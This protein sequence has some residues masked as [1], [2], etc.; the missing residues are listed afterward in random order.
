MW[1]N[2][3]DI[4]DINFT[5]QQCV[6]S[7][8]GLL[9]CR[10][11]RAHAHD[12][13]AQYWVSTAMFERYLAQ[14]KH[15]WLAVKQALRSEDEST[16]YDGLKCLFANDQEDDYE[17]AEEEDAEHQ[18]LRLAKDALPCLRNLGFRVNGAVVLR[19]TKMVV[20]R[21]G[22]EIW[23][24]LLPE[25]RERFRSDARYRLHYAVCIGNII[26]T[27]IGMALML[28]IL[29]VNVCGGWYILWW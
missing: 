25:P 17:A 16:A 18:M 22:H 10:T 6:Y 13:Q 23:E 21:L 3:D 14:S 2:E 27:M 7:N 20:K 24:A 9:C 11:G 28:V 8:S 15:L 26:F 19:S 4:D 1:Y 5:V 29:S 12:L